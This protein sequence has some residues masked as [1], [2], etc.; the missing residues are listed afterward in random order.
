MKACL[1][2]LGSEEDKAMGSEM[3]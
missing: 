2:S 3:L 1:V